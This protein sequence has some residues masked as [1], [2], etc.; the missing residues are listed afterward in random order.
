MACTTLPIA[1]SASYSN[2]DIT[3]NGTNTIKA[4]TEDVF[5][6]KVTCDS[7][8]KYDK[9]YDFCYSE[10]GK[11]YGN[12]VNF[13][14]NIGQVSYYCGA[15]GTQ[16]GEVYEN[17][18]NIYG[19]TSSNDMSAGFIP[20]R[21][22]GKI[23]SNT[24]NYYDGEYNTLR[25]GCHE[26]AS[27]EVYGN[28]VNASGGTI[29]NVIGGIASSSSNVSA[30]TSNEV[31]LSGTVLVK[32]N[33]YGGYSN[34]STASVD[35][36]TVAISGG[37]VNGDIYGGY[38]YSSSANA[39]NNTVTIGGGSID[40]NVYG[41]NKS[42]ATTVGNTLNVYGLNNSAKNIINFNNINFY[43][44]N[45]A[46][47]G[48][49]MLTLTDN[50]GTDIS[51]STIKTGVLQGNS[52]LA[53]GD[54][55][56][57][58]VKNSNTITDNGTT[59]G[60]L[61]EGVSL[62][63]DL[64]IAKSDDG[65]KLVATL[66]NI[67]TPSLKEQTKS[68]V[69][70]QAAAVALINKGSDLIADQGIANAM[71]A[72]G[73]GGS[74]AP[75]AAMSVA[76]MKYQTGSYVDM[77]SWN[78]GVGMSRTINNSKDSLT[79]GPMVI[80]GKGSYDSYLDDGVHGNGNSHYTG[81]GMFARQ[82]TNR[83]TYYEGS[84]SGGRTS[85]DYRS[86]NMQGAG[87]VGYETD[88]SYYAMHL[89]IG[90][91]KQLS[92]HLSVDMYGKYYYSHQGSSEADLTSGETYHFDSID[93]NRARLGARCENKYSATS[94]TY[95]GAAWE[96][97]FSGSARATYKGLVTPSPSLKGGS[98][99]VEIGWRSKPSAESPMNF[100]LA[101]NGWMGKKQGWNV[102]ANLEWKI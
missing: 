79:F 81:I 92:D 85:S 80:Y 33:V 54:T 20:S 1:E 71:Q 67:S 52:S 27:G 11:V 69:E 25:G 29:N 59:Y 10:S 38:V 24:L 93:S 51:S 39:N 88:A 17:T 96:Y 53:V 45:T 75:F 68:L 70:T 63:Y 95:Y 46:M 100:N 16:S 14:S 32:G 44:P 30:V 98:G 87:S 94:T 50:N 21:G 22:T 82:N 5:K 37:T 4:T 73:S 23:Y 84:I 7:T 72:G 91:I 66:T 15:G 89:G 40:G 60:K 36:N 35:N 83:G 13:M 49:T 55:I 97:E 57:L 99:M 8:G 41:S 90:K 48:A 102:N 86:D 6:N 58:L 42:I 26:G 61:T 19:G 18:F 43:I 12:E 31:H 64:S 34:G 2:Q 28:I 76:D 77:N 3:F 78:I 9:H 65:K 56:N 62:E 101:L 47:S 74:M